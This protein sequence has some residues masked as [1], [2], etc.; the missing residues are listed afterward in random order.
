MYQV[1]V[2]LTDE[3]RLRCKHFLQKIMLGS[4]DKVS[5]KLLRL[6]LAIIEAYDEWS[7]WQDEKGK[8][9]IRISENC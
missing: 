6:T 3:E 7:N 5:D 4:H 9:F 1:W 8:R 2:R